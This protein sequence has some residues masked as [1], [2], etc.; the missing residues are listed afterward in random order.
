MVVTVTPHMHAV[1]MQQAARVIS[2]E[3]NVFYSIDTV[4]Q[5]KLRKIE[6]LLQV[7]IGRAGI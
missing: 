7:S 2:Q 1:C 4:F 3:F 5:I 6:K